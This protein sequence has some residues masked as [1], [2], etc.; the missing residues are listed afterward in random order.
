MMEYFDTS[1][2]EQVEVEIIRHS[3]FEKLVSKGCQ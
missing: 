2:V 3:R 1:L